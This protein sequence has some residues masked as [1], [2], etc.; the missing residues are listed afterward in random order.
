MYHFAAAQQTSTAK[1]PPFY[2]T[3]QIE[4]RALR[5]NEAKITS[6]NSVNGDNF[7]SEDNSE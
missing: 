6:E 2:K 5:V 4:E 1:L 3:F 7:S